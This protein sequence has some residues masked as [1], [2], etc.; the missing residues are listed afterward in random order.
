MIDQQS[1]KDHASGTR[2]QD[3]GRILRWLADNHK[4][5]TRT[6]FNQYLDHLVLLKLLDF[7]IRYEQHA[8]GLDFKYDVDGTMVHKKF[9][10]H[11]LVHS[12]WRMLLLVA[13][14]SL[15]AWGALSHVACPFTYRVSVSSRLRDRLFRPVDGTNIALFVPYMY[16]TLSQR[17]TSTST[18]WRSR[19]RRTP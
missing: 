3:A 11:Q 8:T 14:Q 15:L 5:Y 16:P 9:G 13:H 6:A 18:T 12:D 17:K 19:S 1:F 7:H 4:T 10:P 2:A